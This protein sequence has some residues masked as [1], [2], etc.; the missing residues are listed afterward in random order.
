MVTVFKDA[1]VEVLLLFDLVLV[2]SQKSNEDAQS[3]EILKIRVPVVLISEKDDEPVNHFSERVV[4]FDIVASVFPTVG[5]SF[6]LLGRVPLDG[7]VGVL[8]VRLLKFF[9]QSFF[10]L[11]VGLNPEQPEPHQESEQ[12]DRVGRVELMELV[13]SD[14]EKLLEVVLEDTSFEIDTQIQSQDGVYLEVGLVVS[15]A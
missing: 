9:D 6:D 14:N 1:L 8:R 11:L 2:L 5:L 3:I 10:E 7:K 4:V 13:N 12:V 15:P